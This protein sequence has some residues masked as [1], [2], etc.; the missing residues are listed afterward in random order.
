M[1][2]KFATVLAIS[3][4][5]LACGLGPDLSKDRIE[6]PPSPTPFVA[7][8]PIAEYLRDGDAA[9][10]AGDYAAALTPYKRAFEIEQ[11]EQKLETKSWH[12]LVNNL[13]MSYVRTGDMKNARLTIAYGVSKDYDHPPFHYTLACSFGEEGDESNATYHLRKAFRFRNKMPAGEKLADPMTDAC[14]D[15]FA[16]SDAFAKAVAEMKVARPVS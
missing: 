13:A 11:R 10:E 14:F 12:A 3:I 8:K 15:S 16:S 5:S 2:M 4:L 6:R 1:M 7:D 9:F